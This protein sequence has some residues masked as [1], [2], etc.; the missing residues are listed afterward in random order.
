MRAIFVAIVIAWCAPPAHAQVLG[1]GDKLAELD[2]AVDAKGK[3][4]KLAAY[5]GRW[6]L[7][8]IGAAWCE[9]CKKELPVWD[10]LAGETRGRITFV[11]LDIDDSVDDGKAFH[12]RL[13]LAHMIR[14]YLPQDKTAVAGRY[15]AE[16]MPTTVIA[17]PEGRVR[18]VHGGFDARDPDGEYTRMKARLA[19][20]VPIKLRPPA[21]KPPAPKPPS[22]PPPTS[23]ASPTAV[24]CQRCELGTL[25][26]ASWAALLRF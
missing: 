13:K 12:A 26:S 21:V 24:L 2:V 11:A 1:V 7:V 23:P 16:K 22:R 3:P 15:G 10:R 9:P 25:W 17:D 20:L 4:V 19:A 8:T 5:R 18:Y 14:V 6:V